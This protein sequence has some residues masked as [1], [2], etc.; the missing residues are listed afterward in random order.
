MSEQK[1]TPKKTEP[2]AQPEVKDETKATEANTSAYVVPDT[3]EY[4]QE[5]MEQK[6][7]EAKADETAEQQ[8]KTVA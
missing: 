4:N 7:K 3:G 5:A 1:P 2:K 6:P 8:H